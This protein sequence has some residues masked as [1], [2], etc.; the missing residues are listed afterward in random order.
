MDDDDWQ[1]GMYDYDQEDRDLEDYDEDKDD[2]GDP[3]NSDEDRGEFTDPFIGE[4]INDDLDFKPD[5]K[6]MQQA[7]TD[8]GR[9]TTLAPGMG[10]RARK[11][12]RSPEEILEEQLRGILSSDVYSEVTEPRK[13]Q[14]IQDILSLH[15]SVLLNLE[16]LALAMIWQIE[17]RPLNKKNFADF[18]KRYDVS[19]NI[20]LFTYIRMLTV[21]TE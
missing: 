20:S 7:T 14:V 12:M 21:K 2:F 11:A 9:G 13:A 10:K 16:I 8:K 17:N 3:E 1:E 5:F 6:Q 15:N 4:I 19:D 18:T